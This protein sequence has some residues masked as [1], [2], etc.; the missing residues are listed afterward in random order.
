M[1]DGH[2]IPG[3]GFLAG[4]RE[5]LIRDALAGLTARPK[6]LP[7]KWLY[8]SEGTALF[9]A[10]TRL[11][12]YYP[13]RTETGILAAHAEDMANEVGAGAAVIELGPG[14]GLKAVRFLGGLVAPA[15]YVPVDIAADWLEG[16]AAR[17]AD[18]HP[19]LSVL[20][21]VA[22]FTQSFALPPALGAAPRVGFFPGSTIGNFRRE[23]AVAFLA[24]FRETLGSGARLII[25]VDLVKEERRLVEAYD[26][27]A[28]VT[29]A[30]N[31]NLLARL[32]REAG[33]DF[34][35][36]AFT[37][38]AVWNAAEGRIELYIVSARAQGVTLAGQRIAFAAGEAIHT[39]DSHKYTPDGF[40]A[41]AAAAGWRDR[42]LWTDPEQLFSVWSLVAD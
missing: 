13:T 8:D 16:A 18:A 35:L 42:K 39:E 21:V 9:E 38:R 12:E 32:N 4:Q 11:P 40:R 19:R 1:M 37:H 28:G 41:L 6:S 22:D 33:A 7:C 2:D 10:I 26:D 5:A 31:L 25:G 17:V 24:R 36:G 14:D 34:D 29:A 30:F 15:A 27:A 20:P 23:D 3:T